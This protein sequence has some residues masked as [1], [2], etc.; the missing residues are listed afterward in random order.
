MDVTFSPR[1]KEMRNNLWRPFKRQLLSKS[2][3]QKFGS[4]T[5]DLC[6]GKHLLKNCSSDVG[7]LLCGLRFVICWI[8]PV[9]IDRDELR[10]PWGMDTVLEPSSCLLEH[11]QKPQSN[12]NYR[13]YSFSV[14][15]ASLITAYETGN[16]CFEWCLALWIKNC[17]KKPGGFPKSCAAITNIYGRGCNS[18]AS[19][20]HPPP[21]RRSDF[22]LKGILT[23]IS[24]D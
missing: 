3:S 18:L 7:A 21:Q 4:C 24:W 16:M 12:P 9:A 5:T 22:H 10:S 2:Y 23:F 1:C 8:V 19:T 13:I 14:H 15:M 6:L 11:C 17:K 20:L